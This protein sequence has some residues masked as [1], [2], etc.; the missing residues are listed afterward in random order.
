[1]TQLAHV[2]IRVFDR[3]RPLDL[4]RIIPQMERVSPD[5]GEVVAFPDK[6]PRSS[7]S[8]ALAQLLQRYAMVLI[9]RGMVRA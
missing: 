8:R 4:E 5:D 1:M 9:Q 2:R 3:L 6:E 7:E